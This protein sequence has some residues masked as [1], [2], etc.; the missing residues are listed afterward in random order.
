MKRN[1]YAPHLFAKIFSLRISA[2][3]CVSALIR[4]PS[5]FDGQ[6]SAGLILEQ[7]ENVGADL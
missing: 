7:V 3:L 1:F 6:S 4:V 2:V 5:H